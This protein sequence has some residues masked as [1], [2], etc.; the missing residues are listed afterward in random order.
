MVPFFNVCYPLFSS[1]NWQS[2]GLQL[3]YRDLYQLAVKPKSIKKQILFWQKIESK[4]IKKWITT[5]K[6]LKFLLK[7]SY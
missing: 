1:V 5:K 4:K 6:I 3:V 2:M 7:K